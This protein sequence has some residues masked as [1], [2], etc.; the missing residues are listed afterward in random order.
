MS[1]KGSIA[2]LCMNIPDEQI[3]SPNGVDIILYKIFQQSPDDDLF[4]ELTIMEAIDSLYCSSSGK[5]A[6]FVTSFQ[7]FVEK[8]IDVAGKLGPRIDKLFA[9]QMLRVA[10]LDDATRA[11]ALTSAITHCSQS[12]SMV[13]TSMKFLM[14][15]YSLNTCPRTGD[16]SSSSS[17][18]HTSTRNVAAIDTTKFPVNNVLRKLASIQSLFL[19]I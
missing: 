16:V 13:G 17:L 3:M 7:P 12:K 9:L 10:N 18:A 4:Y 6:T 14:V 15:T 11:N 5:L 2:T 19:L 8:Y 1:L